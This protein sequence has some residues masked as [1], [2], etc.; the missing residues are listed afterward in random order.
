MATQLN[1]N[2]NLNTAQ[3]KK[4]IQALYTYGQNVFSKG[5]SAS[6]G[7]K[8][9][10]GGLNKDLQKFNGYIDTAATRVALFTSTAAAITLVS[11]SL[12]RL[13]TDAIEVESA[14]TSIQSILGA[15]T[16]DFSRF[17][18]S[19]FD[20]SQKTSVG[21]FDAA[22]AA[23][24]FARQG[25]SLEKTLGATEAALGVFRVSGGDITKIIEGLTSSFNAFSDQGISFE[26]IAD[27]LAALDANF[28]TSATG[29]IEGLKRVSAT[30][31]DAG[32]EFDELGALIASIRQVSGRTEAV[33]GNGLKTIL[34]NLQSGDI[35]GRLEG[36]GIATKDLA[37]EFRPVVDVIR[38]LSDA[39]EG[40]TD[41]QRADL[42]TK[43][44]GK[45]QINTFRSLIKATQQGGLFDEGLDVS[46]GAEGDIAS[47]VALL[48]ETTKS[49]IQRFQNDFTRLGSTLG[50]SVGKDF[51]DGVISYGSDIVGGLADFF[52]KG[53]P[54]GDAI[55]GA[56]GSALSGPG[57]LAVGAILIKLGARIATGIGQG[58]KS[59]VEINNAAQEQLV[60]QNKINQSIA[61][62]NGLLTQRQSSIKG[63]ITPQ[64]LFA[65]RNSGFQGNVISQNSVN[66]LRQS[67]A[68]KE[69]RAQL[70]AQQRSGRG[71]LA[72]A[73]FGVAAA[74]GFIASQFQNET[75]KEFAS[76]LSEA[77]GTALIGSSFGKLGGA[78]GIAV[79]G[80][81][82]I[83][84]ASKALFDRTEEVNKSVRDNIA[85]I[86]K[87]TAT[88]NEY[89]QALDKLKNTQIKGTPSQVVS[90]EN[91]VSRLAANLADR[92]K[93]LLSA[94]NEGE[95]DAISQRVFNQDNIRKE[96]ELSRAEIEKALTKAF[97]SI[98]AKID[99]VGRGVL[100]NAVG[101]DEA[102]LNNLGVSIAKTIQVTDTQLA[103]LNAALAEFSSTGEFQNIGSI[104]KS[105]ITDDGA[106][107][108]F[109]RFATNTKDG[110]D[111]LSVFIASA[112]NASKSAKDF[113]RSQGLVVKGLDG[114]AK[115]A[116]KLNERRN[117][118]FLGSLEQANSG[119]GSQ[120][121]RFENESAVIASKKQEDLAFETEALTKRFQALNKFAP[122]ALESIISG[123]QGEKERGVAVQVIRDFLAGSLQTV[124]LQSALAKSL[125][126][127]NAS[128]IFQQVTSQADE[129]REAFLDINSELKTNLNKSIQETANK[130]KNLNLDR[131]AQLFGDITE[132][133]ADSITAILAGDAARRGDLSKPSA[134]I[135]AIKGFQTEKN[136][137]LLSEDDI[138]GRS[139]GLE[140]NVRSLLE[141]N[142]QTFGTPRLLK[143]LES[144]EG[145]TKEE[146]KVL[147]SSFKKGDFSTINKTLDEILTRRGGP[148]DASDPGFNELF[149][150][151]TTQAQ[152]FQE[153]P[154]AIAEKL[155]QITGQRPQGELNE[156]IADIQTK[157][158]QGAAATTLGNQSVNDGSLL[159]KQISL[160]DER[161]QA[162][163]DLKKAQAELLKNEQSQRETLNRRIFIEGKDAENPR[164]DVEKNFSKDALSLDADQKREAEIRKEIQNSQRKLQDLDNTSKQ[165]NDPNN[166]GKQ[167][168]ELTNVLTQGIKTISSTSVDA[169]VNVTGS[170]VPDL[171]S[172]ENKAL[173]E[174]MFQEFYIRASKQNGQ[175]PV[176]PPNVSNQ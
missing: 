79:A 72:G 103:E 50:D 82:L 81:Q 94:A 144:I 114:L 171:S 14:M 78:I 75:A 135:A 136:L 73:G 77:V 118:S 96:G 12:K 153:I 71:R 40:L 32:V 176:I 165:L 13:V 110:A 174:A 133:P 124:D 2:L 51:A 35:Q 30:A 54:L 91:D 27:K 129:L 134:N 137:G 16:S 66:F 58:F 92:F 158:S 76:G 37:G 126:Q 7:T 9:G 149:S 119:L 157:L 20:L 67:Q 90:A 105:V 98:G 28:A 65:K 139:K 70:Q 161:Q 109:S 100:P 43:I 128:R 159:Q 130:L 18:S 21:F 132:D 3:G 156:S 34:T 52:T 113:A 17:Q 89:L 83:G 108:A 125:G 55:S 85:V 39:F 148:V 41:A 87:E 63:A 38:D 168:S 60:I 147:E 49:A 68:E 46:R 4:N 59:L 56:I 170:V 115:S 164:F 99:A 33:I 15:T 74:G 69:Q 57:F 127:D 6:I 152:T 107:Q 53:N 88:A 117:A 143:I 61:K 19:L 160:A 166:V 172:P 23:E 104:V 169:N 80:L 24:E 29:L 101:I 146:T 44:A 10:I 36:I 162:Q 42:S 5:F 86:D 102:V 48:N 64:Q 123:T 120:V 141:S 155:A 167:L 25:L 140:G 11:S 151:L 122:D 1:Y 111:V 142:R 95:R 106:S 93:P 173:F 112:L 97:D 175:N 26:Q 121:S 138:R 22:K 8:N 150:F 154:T 45:F 131:L 116:G 31:Q 62:G 84:S 163:N 145:L 47:R